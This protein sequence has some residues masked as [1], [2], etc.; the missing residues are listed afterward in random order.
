MSLFSLIRNAIGKSNASDSSGKRHYI[1]E[2]PFDE[3][4]DDSVVCT[5][6]QIKYRDIKQEIEFGFTT[7]DEILEDLEAGDACRKCVNYL[8][9]LIEHAKQEIGM[10]L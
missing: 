5:C 10:S 9:L 6:A 8:N 7:V 1:F 3:L 4:T 2:V